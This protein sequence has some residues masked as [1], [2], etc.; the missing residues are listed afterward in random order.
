MASMMHNLQGS[1][2]DFIIFY[3]D[4]MLARNHCKSKD[5]GLFLLTGVWKANRREIHKR[6]VATTALKCLCTLCR[7]KKTQCSQIYIKLTQF[8]DH[9]S[10]KLP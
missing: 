7:T 6:I 3:G 1:A 10:R 8:E 4:N 5:S 9:D 2:F